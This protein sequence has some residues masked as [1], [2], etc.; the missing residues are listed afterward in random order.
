M[1]NSKTIYGQAW[2]LRDPN[3]E[4]P[5]DSLVQEQLLIVKG[6]SIV[7]ENTVVLIEDIWDNLLNPTEGGEYAYKS[8]GK[9]FFYWEVN[10]TDVNDDSIV[11]KVKIECPAP[12][13]GLFEEPYDLDK[14]EGDYAK[15]WVNKLKTA[16]DNV[17]ASFAIQ[18]K[19]VTFPGSTYVNHTT[20]QVF[21]VDTIVVKNDDLGDISNLL[22][23]F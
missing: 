6:S 18:R 5:K 22:G 7:S 15:Y 23:L 8:N 13:E 1:S 3:P 4:N 16:K 19:S 21:T 11:H 17:E 12:K 14:V 10:M 2:I 9:K 20:N